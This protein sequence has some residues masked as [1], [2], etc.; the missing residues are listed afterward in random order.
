MAPE[1]AQLPAGPNKPRVLIVSDTPFSEFH[2]PGVTM[3]TLFDGWPAD[4]LAMFCSSWSPTRRMPSQDERCARVETFRVPGPGGRLDWVKHRLG[5]VPNWRHDLSPAWHRRWFRQWR[6]DVVYSMFLDLKTF[7]YA[8]WIADFLDVPHICHIIDDITPGIAAF[9][10]ER[11]Q[12]RMAMAAQR[13]AISE[14]MKLEYQALIGREFLVFHNGASRVPHVEPA[15]RRD[16]ELIIRYLGNVSIIQHSALVDV[17]AA[18]CR[19]RAEGI[20]C[21]LEIVGSFWEEHLHTSFVDGVAVRR[22]GP[23]VSREAWVGLLHSSDLLVIPVAASAHEAMN[24]SL[25]LPTKLLEYLSTGTPTL[26]YGPAESGPSRFCRRHHLAS[27]VDQQN[28]DTI[29]RFLR[30]FATN[31]SWFREQAACDQATVLREFSNSE[32]AAR[33]QRLLVESADSRPTSGE[34]FRAILRGTAGGTS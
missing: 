22:V 27:V 10:L 25:S 3:T 12:R 34:P 4:K 32:I 33:F 18:V 31:V 16:G 9:G 28:V 2:G 13:L 19:A 1:R 23:Y 15:P 20:S 6:P 14:E 24:V 8:D 21:R 7:G 5:L 17:A 11:L 26:V 30:D 29:V